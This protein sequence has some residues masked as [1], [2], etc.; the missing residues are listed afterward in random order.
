[1][2]R[3]LTVLSKQNVILRGDILLQRFNKKKAGDY[4]FVIFALSIII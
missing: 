4:F 2:H 3:S 1:M